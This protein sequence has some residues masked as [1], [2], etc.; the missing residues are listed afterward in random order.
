MVGVLNFLRHF[1]IARELFCIVYILCIVVG[2]KGGGWPNAGA[3]AI[4]PLLNKGNKLFFS[5]SKA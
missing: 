1:Y 3:A 4:F 5:E 2:V